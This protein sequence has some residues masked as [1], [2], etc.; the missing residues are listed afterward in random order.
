MDNAV[1]PSPQTQEPTTEAP[2]LKALGLPQTTNIETEFNFYTNQGP[3]TFAPATL[4]PLQTPETNTHIPWMPAIGIGLFPTN[5]THNQTPIK[6][7]QRPHSTIPTP[8]PIPQPKPIPEPP[9]AL[10]VALALIVAAIA[11]RR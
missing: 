6:G 2:A 7:P 3:A 10:L 11:H 4:Y 1:H 5:L 9:T 8:D